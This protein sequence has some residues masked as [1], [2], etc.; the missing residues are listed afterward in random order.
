M[1][2]ILLTSILFWIAF[3]P[4]FAQNF[5][6]IPKQTLDLCKILRDTQNCNSP[7]TVEAFEMSEFITL[8]EYKKYLAS[9][10]NKD[11]Y[12]SQLP[13]SSILVNQQDY[14]RYI[15]DPQYETFPVLGVSWEDAM[16]FCKWKTLQENP[17][18]SITFVYRLPHCSE[19][20][21]AYHYLNENNMVHDLD[22]LYSDWL[23]GSKYEEFYMFQNSVGSLAGLIYNYDLWC[24]FDKDS[25]STVKRRLVIGSSY[26]FEQAY[27]LMYSF[28]Y[29]GDEGYRN[30]GFRC[31][32]QSID[33]KDEKQKSDIEQIEN[34]WQ[35]KLLK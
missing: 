2:K 18:D 14:Q 10:N 1:L 32:K 25:Y 34:C 26:L 15:N 35:I 3:I 33:F 27:P 30:I 11:L 19:W 6:T 22:S 20:L 21:M 13:D 23:T 29:F 4:L 12:K 16:N 7:T 17:K 5:Y 24:C 28:S 9:I 8:Q 31:V